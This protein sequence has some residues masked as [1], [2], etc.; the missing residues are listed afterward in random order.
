M[1]FPLAFA[2]LALV[3]A[4]SQPLTA[5]AETRSYNLSGFKEIRASSSA[6][7]VLKQGPYSVTA[8]STNGGDFKDLVVEIQGGALVVHRE[9][10]GWWFGSNAHYTVTVTAPSIEELRAN[11]SADIDAANYKFQNLRVEVSSSGDVRLSGACSELDVNVSSSGDFKGTDLRCDSVKVNAS[12]SGDADVYAAKSVVGEASSSGDVRIH[13]NPPQ[14][15][16][17]TSS[18]G[19]I[20]AS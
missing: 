15:E 13:G 12:S 5:S 20:K 4:C 9:S 10:H 19:K 8:E 3:A 16:K 1:R 2:A 6:N 18:S 11:S 14:I 7:V 17:H